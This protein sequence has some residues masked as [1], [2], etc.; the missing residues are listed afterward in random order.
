MLVRIRNKLIPSDYSEQLSYLLRYPTSSEGGSSL[1]ISLLLQQAIILSRD[2]NTSAGASIVLQNRNILGI[3]IEVPERPARPTPRRRGD[4]PPIT[5][6][7]PNTGNERKE[8][9]Q[10]GLPEIIARNILDKSESLGINRAIYNTVSEFR[11]GWNDLPA[12]FSRTQESPSGTSLP[13]LSYQ[14]QSGL[15]PDLDSPSEPR[16]RSDMEEEMIALRNQQRKLGRAVTWAVD[17]LL[18]GSENLDPSKKEA[19]ECIAYVRDVLMMGNVVRLDEDRLTRHVKALPPRTESTVAHRIQTPPV[20]PSSQIP[21]TKEDIQSPTMILSKRDSRPLSGLSR[22]PYTRREEPQTIPVQS[23]PLSNT[24]DSGQ[25]TLGSSS[26][27]LTGGYNTRFL[28]SPTGSSTPPWQRNLGM[29]TNPQLPGKRESVVLSQTTPQ[30]KVSALTPNS[31]GPAGGGYPPRT[32]R[33]PGSGSVG[34]SKVT[35]PTTDPLG[36]LR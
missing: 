28:T 23:T 6:A 17:S 3:P 18:Q 36:V 21:E 29:N 33:T 30:T 8:Q 9:S 26:P 4:R 1:H 20:G 25:D 11:R 14:S 27:P 24:T 13:P 5:T 19:L 34:S 12:A 22:V 10:F 15:S 2:P 16:V 32:P 7:A 31:P 35:S